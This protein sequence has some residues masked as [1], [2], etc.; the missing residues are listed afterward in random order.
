MI[1]NEKHWKFKQKKKRNIETRYFD[2]R[3]S[4]KYKMKVKIQYTVQCTVIAIMLG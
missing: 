1:K 2:C 4:C 3:H